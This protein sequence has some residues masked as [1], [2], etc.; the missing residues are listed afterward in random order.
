MVE[1]APGVT[2]KPDRVTLG[3]HVEQ[4]VEVRRSPELEEGSETSGTLTRPD[5]PLPGLLRSPCSRIMTLKAEAPSLR[6]TWSDSQATSPSPA[7]GFTRPPA[8]GRCPRLLGS[9][10]TR[11]WG[12]RDSRVWEKGARPAEARSPPPHPRRGSFSREELTGYLLRAS[13]ICSKLGLSFLHTF[14]EVTFR[15][16][17]FCDSCNGFVSPLPVVTLRAHLPWTTLTPH[18]LGLG[19][20]PC[21][22]GLTVPRPQTIPKQWPFPTSWIIVKPR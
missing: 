10:K 19:S 7:M 14:Q 12:C 1:W 22:G 4:L 2:P 16:P 13:A 9:L 20:Q 6:R 21:P 18:S 3:R 11:D 17:T 15:K 8:R 5:S